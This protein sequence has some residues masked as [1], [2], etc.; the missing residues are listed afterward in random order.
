MKN[1]DNPR[2][3]EESY[4][5]SDQGRVQ[6]SMGTMSPWIILYIPL[7]TYTKTHLHTLIDT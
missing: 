3:I 4:I 7:L 5:D 2:D 1:N 6:G